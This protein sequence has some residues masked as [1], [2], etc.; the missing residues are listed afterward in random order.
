LEREMVH[1]KGLLK[2]TLKDLMMDDEMAA[3]WDGT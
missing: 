2:E 3:A 1:V